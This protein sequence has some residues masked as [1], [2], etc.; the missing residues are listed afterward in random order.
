M[1]RNCLGQQIFATDMNEQAITE[2]SVANW[3]GKHLEILLKVNLGSKH[4]HLATSRNQ[5]TKIFREEIFLCPSSLCRPTVT[6]TIPGAAGPPLQFAHA[7]A[8]AKS[9]RYLPHVDRIPRIPREYWLIEQLTVHLVIGIPHSSLSYCTVR[10]VAWF[11]ESLPRTIRLDSK[12]SFKIV[13]PLLLEI[14]RAALAKR[15]G[16]D[17]TG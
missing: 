7:V 8:E 17:C 15:L 3:I 6:N 16:L 1:N 4:S 11:P 13:I 12:E 9:G 10:H 5:D 14:L 2:H